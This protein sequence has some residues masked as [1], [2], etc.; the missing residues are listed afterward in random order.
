MKT[1]KQLE[2]DAVRHGLCLSHGKHVAAL[3]ENRPP[4][5]AP[6]STV[7]RCEWWDGNKAECDRQLRRM[8]EAAL[9]SLKGKKR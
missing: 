7:G 9:A 5:E 6:G 3:H 2:A 1:W 8:T 4:P